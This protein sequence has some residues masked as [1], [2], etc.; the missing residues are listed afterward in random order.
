MVMGMIPGIPICFGLNLSS[1][2]YPS[3]HQGNFTVSLNPAVKSPLACELASR[4]DAPPC[5][6]KVLSR[7]GTDSTSQR[8]LRKFNAINADGFIIHAQLGI[9]CR[10]LCVLSNYS[11]FQRISGID[12]LNHCSSTSFAIRARHDTKS[13][14]DITMTS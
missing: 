2:R 11:D 13:P 9:S 1:N 8:W 6:F 3:S 10:K 4:R 14:R 7:C 12:C 5:C